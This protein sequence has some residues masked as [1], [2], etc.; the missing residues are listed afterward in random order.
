LKRFLK[1][2]KAARRG[3]NEKKKMDAR[4]LAQRTACGRMLQEYLLYLSTHMPFSRTPYDDFA[5][6]DNTNIGVPT[7]PMTED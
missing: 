1:N 5:E 2:V 4:M 7:I 3:R 6:K